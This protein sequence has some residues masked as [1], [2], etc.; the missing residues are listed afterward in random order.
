[1]KRFLCN[2]LNKGDD[3]IVSDDSVPDL[4]S[5]MNQQ[6]KRL[7]CKLDFKYGRKKFVKFEFKIMNNSGSG[8][9][10]VIYE[11]KCNFCPLCLV[12]M[13]NTL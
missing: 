3:G 7:I 8:S 6:V 4:L 13:M 10:Y 9:S 5:Q 11:H 1:M 12:L 2:I